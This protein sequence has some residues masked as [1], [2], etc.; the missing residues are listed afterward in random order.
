MLRALVE[1]T[2]LNIPKDFRANLASNA[3][4]KGQEKSGIKISICNALDLSSDSSWG[5]YHKVQIF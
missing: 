2:S 3:F 4:D 5:N 1:N